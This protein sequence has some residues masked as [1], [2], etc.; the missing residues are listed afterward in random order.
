[1]TTL[2]LIPSHLEV[3]ACFRSNGLLRLGMAPPTYGAVAQ[4][5]GVRHV[6]ML[7]GY[8]FLSHPF[9]GFL[10]VWLCGISYGSYDHLEV[11]AITLGLVAA[12][13]HWPVNDSPL[14]TW[15]TAEP[16]S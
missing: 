9:G 11:T 5:F 12:A 7:F 13:V 6:S 15:K 10:G 2:F 16:T 14:M 1:M 8:V 3:R 4:T